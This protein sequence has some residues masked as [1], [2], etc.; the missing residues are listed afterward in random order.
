MT[1]QN[2]ATPADAATP[3]STPNVI[4]TPSTATPVVPPEGKVTISTKEFAQLQR[5]AARGKSAQKRAALGLDRTPVVPADG[6]DP[7]AVAITE[8]NQR[9]ADAERR[10]L[11]MEVKGKVSDLLN[12]DEFK[13]LPKSTKDLILLNPALLTQA[14]NLEEAMLDIEDFVR[15]QV[16]SLESGGAVAIPGMGGEAQPKG[17]ETPPVINAGTPAPVSAD[18]LEDLTKLHGPARS[19]AAI[20]NVIKQKKGV[21]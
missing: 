17:H 2:P 21:Q 18:G 7:N 15:D 10:A 1:N 4:T 3:G 12:K 20:R 6:S 16:I 19:Q 8:A 9:A 14:D 5:D 13:A 11:Q